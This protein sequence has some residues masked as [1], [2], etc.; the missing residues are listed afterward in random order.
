M[1]QGVTAVLITEQNEAI[2]PT[3][4]ISKIDRLGEVT[5]SFSKNMYTEFISDFNNTT[6]N[7]DGE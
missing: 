5:V 3:A 4:R 6:A 2:V 7:S 1:T